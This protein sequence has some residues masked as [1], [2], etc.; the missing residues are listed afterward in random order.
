M[1][2]IPIGALQDA[3]GIR[4]PIV[5]LIR[6]VVGKDAVVDHTAAVGIFIGLHDLPI[7]TRFKGLKVP[8]GVE[9]VQGSKLGTVALREAGKL[10][11][12]VE[13]FLGLLVVFLHDGNVLREDIPL[14]V[15]SVP[16]VGK[17]NVIPQISVLI[18]LRLT[19]DSELLG[20]IDPDVGAVSDV[21]VVRAGT[22][23]DV[24][25][26]VG[27][28]ARA[29]RLLGL[30][31]LLGQSR[32]GQLK[33]KDQK[34]EQKGQKAIKTALCDMLHS[35]HFLSFRCFGK[36]KHLTINKTVRQSPLIVQFQ[37]RLT[38]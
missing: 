12:K 3:V 26:R 22:L 24:D 15:H 21:G 35:H 25:V 18:R 17:G 13:I 6:R 11:L 1:C 16:I 32:K 37:V 19:V 20:L 34:S 4:F 7:Q 10:L 8:G 31:Q 36:Q 38:A 28:V 29:G 5:A 27:H 2:L 33:R 9:G 23:A 14:V 30:V